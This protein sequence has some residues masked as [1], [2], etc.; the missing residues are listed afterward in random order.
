M[1]VI[2]AGGPLG[3]RQLLTTQT[4]VG[5]TQVGQSQV[6]QSQAAPV[7]RTGQQST[8][9]RNFIRTLQETSNAETTQASADPNASRTTQRANRAISAADAQNRENPLPR[10]SLVNILV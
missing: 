7:D 6:G 3:S 8:S 10:G 5:Q 1:D 4:Q 2:G 9:S